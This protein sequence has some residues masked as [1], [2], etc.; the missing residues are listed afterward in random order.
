[1]IAST[2][3]QI[4]ISKYSPDKEDTPK[5]QDPTTGVPSNKKVPSLEGGNYAENGG[6][7]TL[8]HEIISPK[9]YEPL[10]NK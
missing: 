3:D 8:N 1:M 4:K 7:W 9:F 5:A 6:M 2:T 10:T